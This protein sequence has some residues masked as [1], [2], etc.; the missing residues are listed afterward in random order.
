MTRH[1]PVVV[2]LLWHP[3]EPAGTGNRQRVLKLAQ[4]CQDFQLLHIGPG[5]APPQDVGLHYTEVRPARIMLPRLGFNPGIFGYFPPLAARR[6]VQAAL[7]PKPDLVHTEGLWAAGAAYEAARRAGVPL[8][9]AVNNIEHRVLGQRGKGVAAALVARLEKRFYRRA[10]LLIVA[11]KLDAAQ[12]RKFLSPS[13]PIV[14]IVPNGVEPPHEPIEPA[15]LPHPNV[16]F[17]GKTDYPPNAEAIDLLLAEWLPAATTR[18]LDVKGVVV[19]GPGEARQ[20]G[21]GSFTGYVDSIWPYLAAADVCVAPL[22]AGSGTR[23][24][25]LSYLAA[26]S[27]VI[28]TRMAVEGLG[29]EHGKHYLEANTAPAFAE[30]LERIRNDTELAIDLVSQGKRLVRSY[31]WPPIARE[32]SRILLE[33]AS[34]AQK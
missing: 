25:I 6:L 3:L 33:L 2:D 17:L 21:R 13:C 20:T 7:L 22:R 29:M 31:E 32:W 1:R 23:L 14:A 11:S 9:I 27:P 15:L 18:G 16:L 28:A 10:D 5:P 26:G 19:G 8:V 30:A 12:L 24:K 4:Y 34:P